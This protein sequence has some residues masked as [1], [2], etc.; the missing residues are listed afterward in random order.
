MAVCSYSAYVKGSCGSS[1]DKP[2]SVLCVTLANC[3]RPIKAHLKLLNVRDATLA[4]ESQLL[5][6]RAGLF[7]DSPEKL[8]LTV[9]PRHRDLFGIRWRCAKKY[10][11]CPV[12]W[13]QHKLNQFRGDYGVTYNQS[14]GLYKLT[15]YLLPVG[16]QKTCLL[17]YGRQIVALIRR[18]FDR[19]LYEEQNNLLNSL[20]D[21]EFKTSRNRISYYIRDLSGLRK[22]KVCKKAFVKIFGIGKKRITVLLR[23]AQPYSGDIEKDQRRFNRNAKT[24]ELT[25]KTERATDNLERPVNA[26][27][28][29]STNKDLKYLSCEIG[30]Q[31][32]D[33]ERVKLSFLVPVVN[34]T[35]NISLDSERE[36][37]SA[38]ASAFGKMNMD[39]DPTVIFSDSTESSSGS[40]D[41][42]KRSLQK[43]NEFLSVCG[44]I[45]YAPIGQPNKTWEIMSIRSKTFT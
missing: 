34:L 6:A 41:R 37:F 25:L 27:P 2:D 11:L 5:L 13:A 18:D 12:S 16:S 19:K 42:P 24:L 38:L 1:K 7:E 36:T 39:D 33:E 21:V 9:C 32:S 22:I 20:V 15:D 10:C 43:L 26:Q 35:V 30:K 31:S 28:D 14:K 45:E 17:N 23:K 3:R 29:F 44:D 40:L 4:S 8:T